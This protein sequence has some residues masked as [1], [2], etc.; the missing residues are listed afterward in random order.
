MKKFMLTFI[1]A[2]GLVSAAAAGDFDLQAI[3][4]SD[5]QA[6]GSGLQA[7]PVPVQPRLLDMARSPNMP[8]PVLDMTVKLPFRALS[9]RVASLPQVKMRAIDP[10]A[11][12]L[13]RQGDHIA[14]SN[15]SVN[16]NGMIVD[17]TILIKPFFEGRN[18]LAIKVMKVEA[19]IE[20]GPRAPFAQP[21]DKDALM[22]M[23][24]GSLTKGMLQSMDEAFAKNRVQLRASDVL[25]FI[26]DRKSWTLHAAVNPG[27]VAP[28]LPGLITDV[29]LSNFTFDDQGFALS[30]Q[31]GSAESVAKVPGCNLA[32][33]D[34]LLDNFVGQFA[35]NTDFQLH[36]AGHEGGLKFSADGSVEL[37]GRIYARSVFLKP[38]VYFRARMIP[39]LVGPNTLKVRVE[40]VDVDQAYGIGVP[41][42]INNWIQGKVVSSVIATL[43]TNPALAKVMTAR[44]LDDHTV[45]ITLKNSAFLPS[46]ANGAVIDNLKIG[47]GLM[48][49]GFKL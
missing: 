38:N 8:A 14:F 13:F 20:M 3:K 10:S 7:A 27:F 44:K 26:Y 31:T 34:G 1:A 4:A 16:Y 17:P 29:S 33:S 39:Q 19:D 21:L 48:Y 37:A 32:V 46:F 22:Q 15:V 23:V 5:L 11:P 47:N 9:E 45:Q 49:L 18:R 35:K 6:S 25:S 40:R 12:I 28:L 41:G 43:T 36:P 42:F 30:V 24:M 2:A